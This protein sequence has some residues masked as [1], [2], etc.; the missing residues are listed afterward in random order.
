MMQPTEV[1]TDNHHET[2]ETREIDHVCFVVGLFA[3]AAFIAD[4]HVP[5][6]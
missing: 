6:N 5:M 1:T 4:V 3:A 2:H